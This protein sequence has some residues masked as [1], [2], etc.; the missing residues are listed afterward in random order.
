MDGGGERG[1]RPHLGARC[2]VPYAFPG[3]RGHLDGT[4][5]IQREEHVHGTLADVNGGAERRKDEGV[6][7]T[8]KRIAAWAVLGWFGRGWSK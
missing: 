5:A 6:L 1:G 4:A 2:N 3:V 7:R 8:S